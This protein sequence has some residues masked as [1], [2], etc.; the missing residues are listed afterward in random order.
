MAF[1]EHGREL[2]LEEGWVGACRPIGEELAAGDA[3]RRRRALDRLLNDF[4]PRM[5]RGDYQ[6]RLAS[7][8]AIG[9]GVVE[10]AANTLGLRLK[11]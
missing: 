5:G 4:L 6:G 9:S 11:A 10:G 2:L 7:G 1:H 3:T 8:E